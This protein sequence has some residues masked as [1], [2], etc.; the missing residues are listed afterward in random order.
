M[1]IG[2]FVGLGGQAS[3]LT[4]QSPLSPTS[5]TRIFR[6]RNRSRLDRFPARKIAI[7]DR[8]KF[9]NLWSE[10]VA[11]RRSGFD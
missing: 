4:L 5:R 10:E 7:E 8:F 9:F 2:A 6:D 11:N 1:T 3:G